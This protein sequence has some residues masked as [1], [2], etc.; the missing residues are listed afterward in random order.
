MLAAEKKLLIDEVMGV[1]CEKWMTKRPDELR[2]QPVGVMIL[3]LVR[4]FTL[5]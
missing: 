1:V 5:L 2:Q 3:R 4:G